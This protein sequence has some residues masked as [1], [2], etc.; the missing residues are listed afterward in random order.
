[1]PG[2]M[3][4]QLPDALVAAEAATNAQVAAFL[5][6][7]RGSERPELLDIQ[8]AAWQKKIT[9]GESRH[10]TV[11][12]HLAGAMKEARAGLVDAK[13]AAG[14]FQ[15]VFEPAVMQQPTGPK[16]GK[17]RTLAEARNEWNGIL[18]WAVA[19]AMAADPAQTLARTAEKVPPP[20]TD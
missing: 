15:S 8:I 2:Y 1:M 18:A 16:Q 5:A 6:D 4:S 19:Q 12:G 13:L 14:D 7:H 11:T 20:F 3:A 9:A 17:A 10:G